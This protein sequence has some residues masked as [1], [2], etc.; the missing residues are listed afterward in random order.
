M[1]KM[2]LNSYQLQAFLAVART[3]HFQK[4][5]E[6]IGVTG[7]ALTQRI[8]ALEAELEATL[9]VRGRDGAKLTAAGER[10]LRYCETTEALEQEA[11]S[12]IAG[13]DLSGN[14]RIA[15]Y[16]SI[17]QSWVMPTL[18]PII[19][20]HTKVSISF[21]VSQMQDLPDMLM[22]SKADLILMDYHW[23]KGGIEA[24]A[25]GH[26]DFVLI[27]P[28]NYPDLETVYLDNSP[29]D[30]ATFNFLKAQPKKLPKIS[31]RFFHDC[32]GIIN[33]VELG[34]GRAVMPRHLV[35]KNKS[36]KI[37]SETKPYKTPVVLHR[38]EQP[39][40]SRLH[41]MAVNALTKNSLRF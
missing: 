19:R 39:F 15:T 4:A 35:L 3:T 8:Q 13:T 2:P 17:L 41:L 20:A 16:S 28:S 29:E 27:R 5:A 11:L 12:D 22:Q 9:F 24:I 18:A 36:V 37:I 33:G 34:L 38:H 30:Q 23:E 21:S 1:M 25:V 26:E 6:M 10:L 7:S 14:L 32:Y 31:R 40:Y